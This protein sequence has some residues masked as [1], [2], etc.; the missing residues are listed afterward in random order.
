[1]ST[2]K[3]NQAVETSTISCPICGAEEESVFEIS[4][5]TKGCMECDFEGH[6]DLF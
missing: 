1:M 6:K 5:N 3:Q 2:S 4:K